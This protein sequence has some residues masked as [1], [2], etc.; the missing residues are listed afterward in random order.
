M[1]SRL[2]AIQRANAAFIEEMYGRFRADPGSVPEDWAVFFAGFELAHP[3]EGA[4]PARR[5]GSS[6]WSST[7]AS[8]GTSRPG[9]TRWASARPAR[10]CSSRRRFGFGE[11]DLDA[12]G[13][14]GALPA[15]AGAARC[16]E[17][18]AALRRTYCDTI[19][20]EYMRL[21][22]E[23]RRAWLQERMEAVE[24]HP[25]AGAGRARAASCGSCSR[26]T[27]SRSSCTRATRGR[28]ASRS[29][30]RRR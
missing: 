24:N 28:S 7:T 13:G 22:D 2:D 20:V 14:L 11:A 6:A 8:S 16:G 18:L 5:A 9:S 19:G 1:A 27:A 29:R 3:P 17:L 4:G 30:A 21:A 10:R 12:R 23:E 25:P 15:A 26:P